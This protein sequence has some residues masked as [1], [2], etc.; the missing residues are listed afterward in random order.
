MAYRYTTDPS[1]AARA[2][3]QEAAL[4]L[5]MKKLDIAED[6]LSGREWFLETRSVIDAYALPMLRWARAKVPGG[7][8]A[9]PTVS[10]LHDRLA[11]DPAVKRVL[12]VHQAAQK[13]PG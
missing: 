4:T 7:I 11:A 8:G 3:V 9:W 1:E 13:A 6:H 2:K 12:E 10:A 5:V